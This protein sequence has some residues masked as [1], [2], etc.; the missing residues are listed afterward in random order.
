MSQP[1][2]TVVEDKFKSAY[3]VLERMGK[4]ESTYSSLTKLFQKQAN[5][6]QALTEVGNQISSQVTRLSSFYPADLG[7]L[8][9]DL[10]NHCNKVDTKL[11][12]WSQSITNEFVEPM[13]LSVDPHERE[14]QSKFK[15]A[16]TSQQALQ[17]DLVKAEKK[18]SKITKV[19][20][21]ELNEMKELDLK[22]EAIEKKKTDILEDI[23]TFERNRF[24]F[25]LGAFLKPISI[26]SSLGKY[27]EKMSKDFAW[28]TR[29][30]Q[31]TDNNPFSIMKVDKIEE[32]KDKTQPTA[33]PRGKVQKSQSCQNVT[34]RVSS[35]SSKEAKDTTP[36]NCGIPR[37]NSFP[38]EAR[39]EMPKVPAPTTLPPPF[40]L[41]LEPKPV[42]TPPIIIETVPEAKIPSPN[43]PTEP[44][45]ED[46]FVPPPSDVPPPAVYQ[47]PRSLSQGRE[48]FTR[49]KSEL[50]AKP[51][52]NTLPAKN[53]AR[54][55]P[56]QTSSKDIK[57]PRSRSPLK[58]RNH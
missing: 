42:V 51:T 19:R 25:F 4:V 7:P 30:A 2:S 17:K 48:K 36:Q 38:N 21:P 6:L 22:K 41:P 11:T 45:T 13:M 34:Q 23:Q 14:I 16:K 20:H 43:P 32:A 55:P 46:Q 49:T 3:A 8:V 31:K 9:R 57:P 53:S 50:I 58:P 29:Y 15:M 10:S 28:W 1:K 39:P 37:S 18:L 47:L 24:K 33:Q 5:L 40:S 54:D 52:E 27:I 35:R 44:T 56:K 12:G 26:Q